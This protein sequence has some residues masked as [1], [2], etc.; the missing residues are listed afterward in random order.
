MIAWLFI[1]LTFYQI[2]RGA[3]AISSKDLQKRDR[4]KRH[5]ILAG[6][7]IALYLIIFWVIN[8]RRY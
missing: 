5:F 2:V 8:L 1:L 4:A 3:V 7:C 6:L